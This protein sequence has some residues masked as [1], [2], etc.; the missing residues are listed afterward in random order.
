MFLKIYIH[1]IYIYIQFS[2]WCS[3]SASVAPRWITFN[4]DR[5]TWVG[6][7]LLFGWRINIPQLLLLLLLLLGVLHKHSSLSGGSLIAAATL[8]PL[9]PRINKISSSLLNPLCC[10]R[11]PKEYT[12]VR[13]L[14]SHLLLSKFKVHFMLFLNEN[15]WRFAE[16]FQHFCMFGIRKSFVVRVCSLWVW[17]ANRRVWRGCD[18]QLIYVAIQETL[19]VE[20][21]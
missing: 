18:I 9:A 19:K 1:Y 21:F 3:P 16:H 14:K 4:G 10:G 5:A 17:E 8:Q 2:N 11:A 12:A 13:S 6:L 20:V 7:R 15:K